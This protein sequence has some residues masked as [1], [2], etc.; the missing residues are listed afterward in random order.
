MFRTLS[1]A[2][3]WLSVAIAAGLFF[4]ARLFLPD[5]MAASTTLPFL[6][7]GAY[8]AW[9]QWRVPSEKNV[10]ATLEALRDMPWEPFSALVTQA[11]R[12]EGCTVEA[13]DGRK[14]DFLT[15]KGGRISLVACKRWKVAQTGIVPLRELFEARD[16]SGAGSCIYI[17]AG[18][19]TDNA[20]AYAIENSIQLLNGANLATFVKRAGMPIRAKP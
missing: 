16:G 11:F 14:G 19:F 8:A 3:W 18:E 1:N 6:A 17:S 12:N 7:I 13:L 5:L 10:A 4:V 15:R 2:P 9:R 20:H